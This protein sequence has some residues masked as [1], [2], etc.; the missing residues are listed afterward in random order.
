M[1]SPWGGKWMAVWALGL[2]LLAGITEAR[3]RV[4]T[5]LESTYLGDGWFQYRFKTM[6]D[7]FFRSVDMG[8]LYLPFL[9]PV[10]A[11]PT[12]PHCT[13]VMSGWTNNSLEFAY[14]Q[15]FPQV[16][17]YEKVFLVRSAERHFK[18]E[19]S[20][21]FT[22][23]L[24]IY[25]NLLYGNVVSAN[26]V[27]YATM[28]NLVPC[29][30]EEADGSPTNFVSRLEL[31]PDVKITG[32]I[33]SNEAVHGLSY[34]WD[35]HATMRLEAS[36]DLEHWTNVAYIYGTPPTTTWTT[37]QSLNRFG[38]YFRVGLIANYHTTNLPPLNRSSRTLAAPPPAPVEVLGLRPIPTGATAVIR[39]PATTRC[40]ITLTD[41]AGK[42]LATRTVTAT[43]GQDEV[44]FALDTQPGT[45]F[46]QGTVLE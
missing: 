4:F 28:T 5:E 16:R 3:A 20:A 35:N 10:E 46:V 34:A 25:E 14:D 29:I 17:P 27:G 7:P 23:S 18:R 30:A 36:P 13:N 31:I 33:M 1:K 32:L 39:A 45:L 41:K 9:H 6:E 19:F 8:S 40:Q 26:I 38:N 42:I 15:T 22:V 44:K 21:L 12:P 43:G 11:G 24:E 37:N 2:G